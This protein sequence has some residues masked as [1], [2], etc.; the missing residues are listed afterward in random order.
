MY[1]YIHGWLGL[2]IQSL[3]E[4]KIATV[5]LAITQK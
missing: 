1:S 4:D 3:L 5:F 2:F